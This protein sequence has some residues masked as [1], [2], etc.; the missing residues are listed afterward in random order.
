[1]GGIYILGESALPVGLILG[2]SEK[3]ANSLARFFSIS[4]ICYPKTWI[5]YNI[6]FKFEV[7]S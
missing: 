7:F 5:Y 1:M 4:C 2:V 6:E 3:L